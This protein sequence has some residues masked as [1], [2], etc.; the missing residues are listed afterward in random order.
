MKRTVSFDLDGVIMQNPFAAGVRPIIYAHIRKS[1]TL[2]GLPP[3]EAERR[4]SRAVRE[5]WGRRMAAGDFVGAYD[6]DEI[7]GGVSRAFGGEPVPDVAALVRVSCRE[8]RAFALLPGAK[9]GLEKLRAEGFRLVAASN[10]YRAYQ[11]PVLEALNLT[12]LFDAVLTPDTVGYAKPDP[13]FFAA[14]P[15]LFAHVGDTLVHD[16]LGAN[17]AGVMAV[18]LEATLPARFRALPPRERN[19][20][21]G[22]S[23]YLADALAQT[24]Y[25]EYHP[26]ASM[27]NCFPEAVV[28]DVL[29]AAEVMVERF[30]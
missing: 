22:F 19:Q 7:Y 17:A 3:D 6:W 11:Q 20:A 5:S 9:A 1:P 15:D 13:R 4:I 8:K 21:E 12:C 30:C 2:A 26:E 28:V 23:D 29:E 27:R 16:V 25:L 10:G 24:P 18:W 14:I